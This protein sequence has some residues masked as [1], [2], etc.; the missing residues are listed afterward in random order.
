MS[1]HSL[2]FIFSVLFCAFSLLSHV[3]SLCPS[4]GFALVLFFCSQPYWLVSAASRDSTSKSKQM[5]TIFGAS[6]G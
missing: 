2:S 4:L 3:H 6:L 1:S 5:G